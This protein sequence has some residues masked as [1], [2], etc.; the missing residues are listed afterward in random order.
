MHMP[1]PI[2]QNVVS[3]S[4]PKREVVDRNYTSVCEL[5]DSLLACRSKLLVIRLDVSV[6]EAY[7]DMVNPFTYRKGIECLRNNLRANSAFEG[8]LGY[9]CSIEYGMKK[10][11]HMHAIFFFNGQIRRDD[12]GL[13]QFLADYWNTVINKQ[14]GICFNCNLKREY[15]YNGIGLVCWNDLDKVNILKSQVASYLCKPDNEVMQEWRL[16]HRGGRLFLRSE[17]PTPSG[18][19]APRRL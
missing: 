1:I 9:A 13:A 14:I 16:A 2:S 17:I 11:W 8:W 18:L 4:Q 15:R 10:G 12:G 5:I 19:G 3:G 6:L 7:K